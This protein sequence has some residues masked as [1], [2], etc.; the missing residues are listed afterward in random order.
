MLGLLAEAHRA[1]GA[2]AEGRALVHEALQI[3]ASTG[4]AFYEPALQRLESLP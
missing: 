3:V 1:A 4:E 2:S